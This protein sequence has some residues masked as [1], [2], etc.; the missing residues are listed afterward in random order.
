[1]RILAIRG[2]N[3]TSL[4]GPF[5]L[6]LVSAPLGE[7]GVFALTGPTGSGKSTLLDA[8]CLALF[9]RL[10]RFG[11]TKRSPVKVGAKDLDPALRE[12]ALDTRGVLRRGCGE[13]MAA[14]DFIGVDGRLYTATWRV[15]RSRKRADGRLQGVEMALEREDADGTWRVAGKL[16]EVQAAIVD[17]LGLTFDQFRRSVL[18]AQGDFAAF[19]RADAKERASLLEAMTGTGIYSTISRVV[20]ARAA[21]AQGRLSDVH[22][23]L[24]MDPPL[25][26]DARA[27]LESDCEETR[28]AQTAAHAVLE[29]ANAWLHHCRRVHEQ[30]GRVQDTA[31]SL[32]ALVQAILALEDADDDAVRMELRALRAKDAETLDAERPGAHT[33]TDAAVQTA[34]GWLAQTADFADE[35]AER[36]TRALE[37]VQQQ[38]KADRAALTDA[39]VLDARL[40]ALDKA[41]ADALAQAAAADDVSQAAAARLDALAAD[42]DAAR[43]QDDA[44]AAQEA[45]APILAR[46]DGG[47]ELRA[48]SAAVDAYRARVD[49][50]RARTAAWWRTAAQLQNAEERARQAAAAEVAHVETAARAMQDAADAHAG[51]AGDALVR[52]ADAL[53][54]W[55]TWGAAATRT[56]AAGAAAAAAYAA[57]EGA[58]READ[59]ACTQARAALQDA[60]AAAEAAQGTAAAEGRLGELARLALSAG[61]M[62][63]A[64][65]EDAPC[66]VCGSTAHPYA[67]AVDAAALAAQADRA[68]A[69]RA[70]AR[71][72]AEQRVAAAAALA[73][74]EAALEQATAALGKAAADWAAAG[75]AWAALEPPGGDVPGATGADRAPDAVPA[76]LARAAWPALD[77]PAP[78]LDAAALALAAR[79]A[80]LADARAALAT[81]RAA[82]AAAEARVD[83]AR[84]AL[85]AARARAATA[86]G[87]A[88]AATAARGQHAAAW[89]PLRTEAA[90]CAEA[91]SVLGAQLDAVGL[92]VAVRGAAAP[93]PLVLP[94]APDVR[95]ASAG[96][97]GDSAAE[98][99]DAHTAWCADREGA[100]EAARATWRD[101]RRA[102]EAGT[103]AAQ[104][105]A[106]EVQTQTTRRD[107]ALEA[108]A[109]ARAQHAQHLEDTAE[110]QAARAAT[111]VGDVQAV[112]VALD[113]ALAAAQGGQRRAAEERD[114]VQYV[115][116]RAETAQAVWREA[117][118]T[119]ATLEDSAPDGEAPA[120]P[121]QAAADAKQ[122]HEAA[123]EVAT[124]ARAR[125]GVDDEARA[126]AQRL[127]RELTAAQA[128]VATWH[129]LDVV[130]GSHDG[131]KF[132]QY[133][134][135]LTLSRLLHL[136][137]AELRDL[138]GRYVLQPVPGHNLEIQV[139]DLQMAGEVR[140]V[141]S[142]S[143]GETFVVSLALA[144]GL[145]Q[146][147]ANNVRIE[148]LF[149]DEGFGS[150]DPDTLDTVLAVLQRLRAQGRQ[151]GVIS[152]VTAL[153]DTLEATVHVTP[154]APGRSEV[155]V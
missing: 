17:A 103:T 87:A 37:A 25:D 89:T 150:L 140:A 101:H 59:T 56:H 108:A 154:V 71:A 118:D 78:W 125:L 114:M 66:P 14:V 132:R 95:G 105:R 36:A 69:A 11:N 152:H 15:R 149:I 133:A 68:E 60:T 106:L 104:A 63:D 40:A 10:P 86:D 2:E 24:G 141:Q 139:V 109:G 120:E 32:G 146:L 77:V 147:A 35:S 88:A 148:S 81:D 116:R 30:T 122:A 65:V 100:L 76:L 94:E 126:R 83:A 155:R 79:D 64:L 96:S 137:N 23:K 136:A 129:A 9:D 70:A 18:L 3:L 41:A 38:Q 61:A 85:D 90:A 43:A 46:A 91:Q 50:L 58:A 153:A 55:E 29:Q 73:T 151:V 121:A 138:S 13:G 42:A 12:G 82:A 145:S 49:A 52:R 123:A 134:Q 51:A 5:A 124:A 130:V 39:Q 75:T 20:H 111:G 127:E 93:E 53:S 16:G 97:A 92:G 102:R 113:A 80:L 31:Q 72:T 34:L 62:R 67:D 98:M 21:E 4:A 115:A 7:A 143:G 119:L 48:A 110:V 26:A 142:L 74:A 28:A 131:R 45:D 128:E 1:M 57:A 99:W 144:L 22:S 27:A 8:I 135:G 107:A 33:V 19:L 44:L 54:A 47:A 117:T 112:Q 6:D 84:S